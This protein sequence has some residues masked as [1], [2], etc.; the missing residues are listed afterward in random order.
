MKRNK[1]NN[2]KY[3][4]DGHKFD[5]KKEMNRYVDLKAMERAGQI[6]DLQCQVP[7]TLIPAYKGVQRVCKYIADFSYVRDGKTIVEDVKGYRGGATYYV[8]SIKKKLM[9]HIFGIEVK[10]I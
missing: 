9:Y 7:Y 10:E 3:E 5:S 6:S 1:L 2:S 4:L 8:F